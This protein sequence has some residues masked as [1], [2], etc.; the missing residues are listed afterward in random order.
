MIS[1][2]SCHKE[3]D[4]NLKGTFCPYC[5]EDLPK[6]DDP[7][8]AK[9]SG[10]AQLIAAA[11]DFALEIQRAKFVIEQ[12]CLVKFRVRKQTDRKMSLQVSLRIEHTPVEQGIVMLAP[13]KLDR[14]ALFSFAFTPKSAGEFRIEDLSVIATPVDDPSAAWVYKL[15]EDE[16]SLIVARTESAG[17]G[18]VYNIRVDEMMASDLKID[19]KSKAAPMEVEWAPIRLVLDED[20]TRAVRH[21]K[22]APKPVAASVSAPPPPAP[23]PAKPPAPAGATKID[24]PFCSEKIPASSVLCEI[25]GSTL[26][27][28]KVSAPVAAAVKPFFE[29][30]KPAAPA[31]GPNYTN[32]ALLCGVLTFF[33]LIGVIPNLI[34]M[35]QANAE[36]KKTGVKPEGRDMLVLFFWL[37]LA[38][39]AF[40]IFVMLVYIASMSDPYYSDWP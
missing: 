34:F 35:L 15:G 21:K 16:L 40:Y 11:P 6:N 36:Y 33:C 23:P 13:E 32:H 38:Y 4:S 28:P 1:C 17:S 26:N 27:A 3:L 8:A 25:C 22:Q 29:P 2:A 14:P 31:P 10:T 30:P 7:P 19:D 9:I 18:V 5:G 12:R 39:A 20:K 37:G 24:C